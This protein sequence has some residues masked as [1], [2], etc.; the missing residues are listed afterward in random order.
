MAS[1][2][3]ERTLVFACKS[4]WYFTYFGFMMLYSEHESQP[5]ILRLDKEDEL[6]QLAVV[7]RQVLQ[8]I[9]HKYWS[10]EVYPS[11]EA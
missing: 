7:G 2:C 3:S 9:N 10:Y 5:A 11:T 8:R 4:I 1:A 6:H